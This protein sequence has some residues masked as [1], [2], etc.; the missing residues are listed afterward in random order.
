MQSVSQ[1]TRDQDRPPLLYLVHRVPYPPDKGDRIR[2]FH[3]LKYL[4]SQCALY[5][6]CLADEPVS[7]EVVRALDGYCRQV[8]VVRLPSGIRWLRALGS[9]ARG[10]T[11]TEGAFHSPALQRIVRAW[12]RA[13][14][15]QGVLASASSMVPYLE[16]DE[17]RQIPAVVDLVDVDSQ[18]WLDY[19]AS[20][21]GPRA[22]L[23][24]TEGR[25]LRQLEQKLPACVRA[26][27]LVSEAEAA[28]YRQ[29]CAAGTVQAITNGVNLD[30]FRPEPGP[31]EPSCV[32]TGALDYRPN[33]EGVCWFCREI[34]PAIHQRRPQATVYLVG[35][36]PVP[37][38]L[39]LA[40]IPGVEVVGQVPDVRPYLAKAAVAIAPLQI[41]RGVQNKVLEA[42]AMGKAAVV[43]TQALAGLQVQPGV[44]VL[45]ASCPE[46]WIEG[47]LR[48]LDNPDLQRQLGAAGRR[49]VE[50][51]HRWERCLEPLATLLGLTPAA[52]F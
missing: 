38:V 15:F 33:V 42:L 40:A 20:S 50:E 5:L 29:F 51:Q 52:V 43:S 37:A 10:R 41:A 21:R 25:R 1:A 17:L 7:A 45:A 27:T 36:Q 23:Y 16:L 9:L 48:V 46:E 24:R 3:I 6:A 12:A 44:Q 2:A 35:R 49:Y 47:V 13:I 18:K 11:V 8:A 19:A 31:G 39:Q 28:L 4:S 32:F 30:H 22:W 34:W 14:P 26:V